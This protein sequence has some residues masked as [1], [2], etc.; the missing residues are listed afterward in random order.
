MTKTP[1]LASVGALTAVGVLCFA[2]NASAL[3]PLDLE[4]GVKA[5]VGT[6]PSNVP[7]G[8]PNPLGFGIGGRAGVSILGL[9]GGGSIIY[10]LGG[11]ENG[12]SVNTLMYGL[13]AGYGLKLLDLLT[14]RAQLG[15]G[16]YKI[17]ASADGYSTSSSNLYLEPGLTGLIS[18]PGMPWFV[19]ADANVLVLTGV[20]NGN[21]QS[22]TDTGF[23][24]HAQVG[25][26]F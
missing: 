23:T 17:S 6:T 7:S 1:L 26:T 11:S 19:G 8:S 25:Y 3:G 20:Q 21:G 15:L 5:G 9:Y 4:V 2:N 13:E 24:L 16:S 14:V 10:Y 18:L 12:V 22:Q